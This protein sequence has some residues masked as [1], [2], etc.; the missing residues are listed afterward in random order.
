M[1]NTS[2]NFNQ[3][4]KRFNIITWIYW[5]NIWNIFASNVTD[6]TLTKSQA[7]RLLVSTSDPSISRLMYSSGLSSKSS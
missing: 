1:I 4:D 5:P 2:A 3:F 6:K 7:A